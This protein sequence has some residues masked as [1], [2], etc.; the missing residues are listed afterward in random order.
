MNLWI[1]IL[2]TYAIAQNLFCAA[3]QSWLMR[4]WTSWPRWVAR[5]PY[6]WALVMCSVFLASVVGPLAW[7]TFLREDL[8]FPMAVGMI[9]NVLILQ[10]LS[11]AM[12]LVSLVEM[13]RSR[14][15]AQRVAEPVAPAGISRRRFIYLVGF[16]AAPATAIGMGVHGAMTEDDLR[17]R[18]YQLPIA[19]LPPELEGFT[20]AHVSDLHSGIFVGPARL[21]KISDAT[22][23]LKANLIAI[24]GDIVNRNMDEFPAALAAMQRMEA[25]HG[26]YLCEGNHDI[27]PGYRSVVNACIKHG[28]PMLY[29][30]CVALPFGGGRLV[31]GGLPWSAYLKMENFPGLV[32]DLFPP[33]QPGDVRVLLAHHPDL[34]DIAQPA[35]L[36]LS[37][38]T[39]GG[40][41]MFGDGIG[42]GRLRFKYCSG[43]FERE[44]TKMIVSNGCGDWFPCR[45]GAPAEIGLLTLTKAKSV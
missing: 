5:L 20:I 10:V 19:N 7:K 37:G 34:F 3:T 14:R 44:N 35:D 26:I 12:I 18:T 6:F 17:V 22:N 40:Q 16:G 4:R 2:G 9:W 25:P 33:R 23:D 11:P 1:A 27:I 13:I 42:L 30:T 15:A 43:L 31:I 28:L 45:I 36:V 21:K 29:A 8:Y 32:G 39:H 38:H 41:I 24:T